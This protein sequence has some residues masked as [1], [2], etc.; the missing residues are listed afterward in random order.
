MKESKT[1][2]I[3]S[4]CRKESLQEILIVHKSIGCTDESGR[5]MYS[6]C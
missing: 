5:R 2:K 4:K 6:E 3:E 1:G